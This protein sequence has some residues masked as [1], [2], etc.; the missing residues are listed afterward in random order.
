MTIEKKFTIEPSDILAISFECGNCGTAFK[1]PISK[2]D[3]TIVAR[4]VRIS[5]MS[6]NQ[7][8]GYEDRT[9]EF[10][11]LLSFASA[12]KELAAN[13]EGRNLKLRI[14]LRYADLEAKP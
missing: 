12:L 13:V 3:E 11:Q 7:P 5:C 2:L 9:R 4:Q 6:C 8:T 14:E 10:G 1:I